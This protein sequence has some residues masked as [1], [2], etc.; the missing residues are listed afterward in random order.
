MYKPKVSIIIPV[1]N[2]SN[3]LKEAIE[4]ALQQTY[5]NVEIIVVN[6]GSTDNDESEKIALS[7][8][9]K[10]MYLSKENG[11]VSSALNYAISYAS[12]EWISWLSHDDLY[13]SDK[14]EKQISFVNSLIKESPDINID[15]IVLHSATIS[16]D[17]NGKTIKK[18][19]YQNVEIVENSRK[20]II[21]NIYNYRLSGC[22]FLIPRKAFDD[23]GGFRED[24]RTV[25]DVE[26]WYRLL[27]NDYKFYCLKND[28]LVK[29]RS[30]GR[31]VGKTKLELFNKELNNLY[32]DIC[33]N[34]YIKY[35]PYSTE[36]VRFYLGLKKRKLN[37]AAKTIKQK[38]LRNRIS[39]FRYYFLLPID[40]L[41][42]SI[43][44][45]LRDLIKKI[46]RKIYVK[47]K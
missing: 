15:K 16:I 25:S 23:V 44:G 3:F 34:F 35:N 13:F 39:W 24:I 17:I 27:F 46:Y 38:Y 9:N 5:E 20:I 32:V 41:F 45:S 28:V 47:T 37:E 7:Y 14:I 19:S 43:F 22:S 11:G 21:D 42:W 31:Q 30:H 18:P 2:G 12:G 1:Y 40:T 29:N 26:Y 8:G 36:L 33:K 4:S 6:D 10:I